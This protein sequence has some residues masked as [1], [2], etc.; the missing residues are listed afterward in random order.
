MEEKELKPVEWVIRDEVIKDT[1]HII[2]YSDELPE[3]IRDVVFW[4]GV[5]IRNVVSEWEVHPTIMGTADILYMKV[6]KAVEEKLKK[7]RAQKKLWEV[8]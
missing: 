2:D 5:L 4:A 1:Q 6:K 8:M 7:L 3:E